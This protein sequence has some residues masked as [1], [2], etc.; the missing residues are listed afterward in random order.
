MPQVEK[1]IYKVVMTGIVSL[2]AS[3][4]QDAIDQTLVYFAAHVEELEYQI[5]TTTVL[6]D[7]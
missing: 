2:E 5:T 7:E 4:N 3:D 6:V 1:T